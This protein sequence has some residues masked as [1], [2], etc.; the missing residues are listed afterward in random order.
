[1]TTSPHLVPELVCS[2]LQ[3]SLSFYL[4]VLGFSIAFERPERRFAYL[5][6]EGVGLMLEQ[7]LGRSFVNGELT[8]PYG[9]GINL[10]IEVSDISVLLDSVQKANA[11][12]YLDIEDKWY[13]KNDTELG[14]RQFVIADP[15]GYLL[16]F[17][18]DLGAWP[19]GERRH[20]LEP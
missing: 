4:K 10:M 7:P 15:D 5:E 9:R 6:R 12:L 13:R 19:A 2:D 17:F 1:M 11:P 18:Q 16:R 3:R 14:N 8:H 20:D